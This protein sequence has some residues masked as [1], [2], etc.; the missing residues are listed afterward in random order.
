MATLG[1]WDVAIVGGGVFGLACACACSRGG[2]TSVV[3]ERDVVGSGASGGPVGAMAPFFPHP[4]TP[5]KQFQFDGLVS[6]EEYWKSV[7]CES[8]T[9]SG[10]GRVGRVSPI[11]TERSRERALIGA[12]AAESHWGG[13]FSVAVEPDDRRLFGPGYGHFG[14]VRDTLSARIRPTAACVALRQ[15]ARN[16]GI[17]ILERCGVSRV[18][19][20]R[21]FTDAGE[22]RSGTTV[23]A[24]GADTFRLLDSAAPELAG[25]GVKGQ[26]A[27]VECDLPGAPVIQSGRTFVVPHSNGTAGIG[28]TRETEWDNP[29]STDS[30]LDNVI[31]EASS[32]VPA[33]KDARLLHR[34]AGLRPRAVRSNPLLGPVPG[35]CGLLVATGGYGIGFSIAH[36]VGEV[37]AAMVLGRP[38]GFPPEFMP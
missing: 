1:E 9:D 31:G 3:V 23:L 38:H 2:C 15:V 10:Y 26:A 24:A 17:E 33:L 32:I 16:L 19:P 21:L 30:R 27:Q 35:R 6:A 8:G 12:A 34:W 37:V 36:L 11:S 25:G 14:V 22:V 4:W 18:E 13:R 7:E 20:G 29:F 28:S 5:L